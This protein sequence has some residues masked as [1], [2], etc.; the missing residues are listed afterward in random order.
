MDAEVLHAERDE[1]PVR[2]AEKRKRRRPMGLSI[3]VV[4]QVV[5]AGGVIV[6]TLLRVIN[7]SGETG[8]MT[9]LRNFWLFSTFAALIAA[10]FFVL[11]L[12]LVSGI[13]TWLGRKWGWFL[14]TVWWALSIAMSLIGLL[15]SQGIFGS[16]SAGKDGLA[17]CLLE[18]GIS[19]LVGALVYLY[20]FKANVLRYFGLAG[21]RKWKAVLADAAVCLVLLAPLSLGPF[22]GWYASFEELGE[23][24]RMYNCGE[25]EEVLPAI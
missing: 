17:Y 19:A 8:W 23:L 20:L 5:G 6:W 1:G 22:P 18:D 24:R 14:Q 16:V 9:V 3:L 4:F 10:L 15:R 7:V 13:G 21:L 2:D 12:L 11:L 25:Y